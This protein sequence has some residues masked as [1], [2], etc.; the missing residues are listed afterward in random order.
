MSTANDR[1]CGMDFGAHN[2]EMRRAWEA[3][4]AG[5]PYRVP[6]ILGTNS[7]YFMFSPEANP[8]RLEFR[9]YTEDPDA[10]FDAQLR[11]QRWSRF[12]LLQDGPLGLPEAGQKWRVWVDFQNYYEAAWLGCPVVY[13]D[14]EVP[15]TR[16]VF[17]D[18]P[19]RVM[20]QGIPDPF[21]G[22]LA[23]GLEYHERF[24]ARAAKETYLGRE[25]EVAP[26][27]CGVGTDGPMT[28]ACNLFGA[29][30][31]CTAMA[32]EPERLRVLLEFITGATIARM[33][34]WRR[35]SGVPVPQEGFMMADD[36]I[37]L[38][39]TAMYRDHILPHHRR[40]Y[41]ALATPEPP[42]GI[43][44][45]GNASRHFLTL[46]DELNVWTFDTGFPV[47]FGGLRCDLGPKA[48]I[49]GGPHVELL[50]TG[51][52]E[53]VRDETRRIL[54]SGILTGGG[55]FI[56]REGNNLAP[57]TPPENTE[58]MYRAGR[59]FGRIGGEEPVEGASR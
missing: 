42:R 48:R 55:M 56:L 26:P 34:A 53:Q 51:T 36:S 41:D 40:L 46:R 6:I 27:G 35:L 22:A 59:E 31:V 11:F 47:D 3:Y 49:Q 14:G 18:C 21:G 25:I 43:H 57:G 45:C 39:S 13:V 10:M 37:A 32:A 4:H 23:R 12:N 1:L 24:K 38:I 50:R 15:D 16:P 28:V 8:Q 19:E 2:A 52:P 30:F 5:T 54:E 20:E 44:L 58:A 17:A 29:D 7:R 9:D 33:I